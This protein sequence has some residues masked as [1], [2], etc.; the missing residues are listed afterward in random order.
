VS[1]QTS[2]LEFEDGALFMAERPSKL[3]AITSRILQDLE[4]CLDTLLERQARFLVI[5]G[6]GSRAFSAGTDLFE[7]QARSHEDQVEKC[8]KARNLLVRLSQA[9]IVSVAAVNG[10]ALGGGL[11]L[12]MACTLRIATPAAEFS[13][14]EIKLGLLPAYAGTQMLPAIVG[15]A[16]AL[17][18]MLTGRRF[19]AREALAIGLIHRI[20]EDHEPIVDA[21]LRFARSVTCHSSEA[22]QAI[23]ACVAASGGGLSA[24]GLEAEERFVRALFDSPPARE[25]LA[26][27][28]EKR[29]P[30]LAGEKSAG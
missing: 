10:L 21:A 4:R 22:V 29:T 14:P 6:R 12:A 7:L 16:R 17:E 9:P 5:S 30:D 19:P 27:F 24:S 20:T 2:T 8:A 15:Q 25:R 3:N 13:L 18:I 11:E 23:R 26:A 1:G 28:H